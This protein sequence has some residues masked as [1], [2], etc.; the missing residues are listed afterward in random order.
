MKQIIIARHTEKTDLQDSK[1]CNITKFGKKQAMEMADFLSNYKIDTIL[2]SVL[3]RSMKTA[4]IINKRFKLPIIA[5]HSLNEYFLRETGEGV[6]TCEMLES[7]V[8]S[9]LY[10]LYD[11]YDSVLLVVH[12][13]MAK[14]IL[15]TILNIDY[16]ESFEYFNKFGEVCVL[17]YDHKL[18]DSKWSVVQRFF[19]KECAD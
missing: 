17:R 4:E 6:E 12:S 19:P 10:S 7:R 9:K 14:T 16:N 3:L 15:R 5:T 8:F 18:G 11:V 13:A 2:T 1:D